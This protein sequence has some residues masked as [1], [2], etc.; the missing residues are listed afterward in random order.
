MSR[1]LIMG[2]EL[3]S[4][5][6]GA[7]EARSYRT[8]QF[9][10][11]LLADGHEVCLIVSHRDSQLNLA[12]PLGPTLSYHRLNMQKR[13]WRSR[14]NQ[15]HG[16]F[17]PDAVL[18]I[19][20]NNCL[21]AVRI[22]SKQP[23]WMDLYGDKLAET[24]VAEHTLNSNRGRR[25]MLQYL[26]TV[27]NGGDVY[28]TCG[29][30]QMNALIGQLG[31][32]SRLNRHTLGYQ[33]VHPVLP[34]APTKPQ[35]VKDGPVLRGNLVADEAF[36]VMWCGGYNV[37]TDVDT[38]FQALNQAMSRNPQIAF[39]SVGAGVKF[40]RHNTYERFLAMIESSPYRQRFHMLG[41]RP[42]SE[43][44]NLYRQADVGINLDAFHY[45]TLLGTRTRLVE[46][47]SYGL[48]VITSLGCELSAIIQ[49]QALGL[50]FPIGDSE[51]LC[52]RILTLTGNPIARRKLAEQA[53][54]Y[55]TQQLSFAETT[56]PFREWAHQPHHAPDRLQKRARYD[57]REI[58]YFLRSVLRG[59]LW[60]L[61]ALE[62]GE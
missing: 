49:N 34:G 55:A 29:T 54:Q 2:Y 7:I 11:P 24:Q 16:S 53:Q 60:Q 50:T 9:I 5:A 32:A 18:A 19:M 30:P 20:F 33:F 4:M 59:V 45:E 46:M 28:S 56:R 35:N 23:L 13:G 21:R 27:L 61:W 40:A 8:W 31:M 37:W 22:A 43:I 12:H 15:V 26:Q 48:P 1:I 38:L 57:P 44:P 42:A 14:I 17:K 41:W 47:M 52:D 62:R 10:E 36:I 51:A 39:V 6:A 58:E 25:V 3:P